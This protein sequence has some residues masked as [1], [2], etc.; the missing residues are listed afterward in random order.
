MRV[1]RIRCAIIP[2][3]HRQARIPAAPSGAPHRRCAIVQ[4]I[5]FRL[6]ALAAVF[7]VTDPFTG[8]FQTNFQFMDLARKR[9]DLGANGTQAFLALDHSGV[10]IRV[11]RHA[12][13]VVAQPN[14]IASDHR[15]TGFELA[16]QFERIAQAVGGQHR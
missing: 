14:S 7:V 3:A 8:I 16:P 15:L 12:Q 5:H 6:A 13:P 2:R 10:R 9:I 4:P 11:A 1:A